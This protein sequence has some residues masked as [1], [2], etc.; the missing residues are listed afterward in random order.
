MMNKHL[1]CLL[2]V[3][4]CGACLSSANA[5]TEAERKLIAASQTGSSPLYFNPV[6][7]NV[8][9]IEPGSY[10]NEQE[11]TIRDGLPNFFAKV[12]AGKPVS[13]GYIGGSITQGIYCYRTQSAKYISSLYP[14]TSFKWMNAGVSG[15]GTDLGA[16]RIGDQLLKYHPDLIFVEFAVNGAYQPGMEGIIRQIIRDNPSTDICLIY[17]LLNGQTKVYSEGKIPE[18]IQGLENIARHYN[19]PSIHLGME[20]AQLEK[21]DKLVWKGTTE[22]ANGRIV[23]SNDGIHPLKEGGNIYAAAIARGFKK[24]SSNTTAAQHKLPD[25]LIKDNWE[26]ATLA[27]PLTAAKFDEYWKKTDPLTVNY[28]KPFAGWFPNIMQAE[29]PGASFSFK[30]NGSMFGLFD[31]GGP[32]VGQVEILIDGQLV[33]L[34]EI[35]TKGYHLYKAVNTPAKST[36]DRFNVNCN[37]RYRGQYD[38]VEV[39][40]GEHTVVVRIAA[41]KSDKATIL[42]PRQQ[43]D[44]TAHPEKYDRTVLYLGKILLKGKM[45]H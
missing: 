6:A 25:A 27:D 18:N 11:C 1:Y 12:K 5:Q 39:T 44:I 34:Q 17:T 43:E 22:T 30:F 10:Y 16:C 42:G 20:A 41:E 3:I 36:L 8:P 45:V 9:L 7:D 24:M 32:E 35:S 40:P 13:M 28:L 14:N 29:Q 4:C 37:N 2:L 33:Q 23:F 38:L 31:V 19:I 15:T 21:E 26:D